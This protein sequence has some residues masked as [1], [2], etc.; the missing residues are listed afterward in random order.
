MSLVSIGQLDLAVI[1]FAEPTED[2]RGNVSMMP[3]LWDPLWFPREETEHDEPMGSKEKWWVNIPDDDRPWLLKLSRVDVRDGVVSGEDW[4]EWMVQHLGR[5]LGVPTAEVRPACVEGARAMVSR[6]VLHDEEEALEHGNSL[7]SARF[8]DYEQSVHG[9]NPGYTVVAVYEALKG[10]RPPDEMEWPDGFSAYDV[11]VGYL[12][13]DAW[14][15]GRDRHHENWAVVTKKHDKRLAPSFDHGNALGFQERD[16]R[17]LRMLHDHAQ[18]DRWID[19]GRSRH[20]SGRPRLDH[21]AWEALRLAPT[22]TR[23]HWVERMRSINDDDVRSLIRG[24]PDE[25]MS[26]GC[27]TFVEKLLMATRRRF[28]DGYESA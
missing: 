14:V 1:C 26:E 25:I 19:R 15:A 21:L 23:E 11:W 27:R 18:F 8:E 2:Y 4:A 22:A 5:L 12:V 20:F 16:A 13:L 9:E 3:V 7:L 10:V 17:R 6:S 28:L 24:V